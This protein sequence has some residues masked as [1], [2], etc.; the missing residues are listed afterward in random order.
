MLMD[1]VQWK[2]TFKG[3]K[4]KNWRNLIQSRN[5]TISKNDASIFNVLD[6]KVTSIK[7][8]LLNIQRLE[9]MS[10]ELPTWARMLSMPTGGYHSFNTSASD[11]VGNI[12]ETLPDTRDR[13]C[14]VLNYD[15][16]ATTSHNVSTSVII[17][18]HNEARS[19]LLRAV[20]SVMLRT[21]DVL[22][23]EI[24]LVDDASTFAW[25]KNAL[26]DLVERMP[27]TRLLRLGRR[28]GLIRAR[29]AGAKTASGD[30]LV[31]LDAHA[32]VNNGW[33][34]PLLNTILQVF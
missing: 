1:I 31:F 8:Y 10:G 14:H 32:E 13:E 33:L 5:S 12:R 23:H 3:Y 28:Q 19:T 22:L 2:H 24:I 25:L 15:H 29:L 17:I 20:H 18:F 11:A 34:E 9:H 4:L 21:P 26:D 7:Q 27:K 16:I 30:V 6:T